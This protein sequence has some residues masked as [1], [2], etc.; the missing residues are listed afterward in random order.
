[1]GAWVCVQF[2]GLTPLCLWIW[3]NLYS[4]SNKHKYQLDVVLEELTPVQ[5][6]YSHNSSNH[7]KE[8]ILQFCKKW[9]LGEQNYGQYSKVN[10]F[11]YTKVS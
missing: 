7:T 8:K 9:P 6:S 11:L 1:M 10:V 4:L 2:C 5:H 3:S